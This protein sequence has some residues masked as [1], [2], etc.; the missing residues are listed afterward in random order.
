MTEKGI[1]SILN[2]HQKAIESLT[3][4]VQS[5]SDIIR[6]EILGGKE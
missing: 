3:E 4:A 5:L 1:I 6:K 2:L